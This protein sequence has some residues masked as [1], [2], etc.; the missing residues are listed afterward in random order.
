MSNNKHSPKKILWIKADP[1]YPLDSGGKIRTFQMLKEWHTRHDITY[2]ALFPQGMP[3][4]AKEHALTYSS[5][6]TWVPWQDQPKSSLKFKISALKNLF[7]SKDPYVIDKYRSAKATQE[8]A[9]LEKKNNYDI[10]IADFLSMTP[11]ILDSGISPSKIIVFQHN[12]ES[13]I[14]KRHF[15]SAKNILLKTYMRIQWKRYHR[16]EQE[17]CAKF[18]GVIAVSEDDALRFQDE[19]KLRNVLGHV[20]TGVNTEFFSEIE[21][22]PEPKHIVFLGSMDWMPNIDGILEFTKNVYPL[23]KNQCPD[24]RLTIIGR[25]P[26]P[27]IVALSALDPSIKVTGTVD[28]VRPYMSKA[29]V[30]VVPLR[31]GGGTRIKIFEAMAMG[32]PVVSS[33]IGAEGLPVQDGV[34][35]HVADD[36]NIF[37]Q[38]VLALLQN[39]PTARAMGDAGK[40]MVSEKF[41]WRTAVDQFDQL[42]DKAM[43]PSS[44]H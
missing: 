17:T 10:V 32:I 30:S 11:N 40:H 2:L 35:I 21:Y 24:V 5:K 41:S 19:F 13:Q 20:P 29:T 23:I 22:A 28:D 42:C 15:E 7:F 31:V 38:R 25:N 4:A 3:Q 8:I 26:T 34:N 9:A 1:L 12:V 14:W 36:A 37:S 18:K 39:P 43:N 33:T 16:F 6:Q 27:A 44:R